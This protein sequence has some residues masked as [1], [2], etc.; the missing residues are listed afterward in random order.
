MPLRGTS[1]GVTDVGGAAD[2]PGR[3]RLLTFSRLPGRAGCRRRLPV[4]QLKAEASLDA[5]GADARSR[6]EVP[7]GLLSMERRSEQ[8]AI[9]PVRGLTP[10][11]K[12][13]SASR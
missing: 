1:Q 3:C 12:A 6:A 13:A 11:Q 8:Y 10:T 5:A 2:S 9:T 7:Y 4:G